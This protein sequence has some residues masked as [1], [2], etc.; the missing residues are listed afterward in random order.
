MK[1]IGIYLIMLVIVGILSATTLT[2]ALAQQSGN[3]SQPA[4]TDQTTAISGSDSNPTGPAEVV[5]PDMYKPSGTPPPASTNATVYF[6][7]QDEN[8]SVTILFLYNTNALT[9]TVGIQS[10]YINGSLTISTTL[11]VPPHGLVRVSSDTV[12]TVSASWQN[13]VLVNFTTFSAYAKMTLPAAIKADG[14]V[15]WDSSG[16]YDPLQLDYT[17]P[18]RFSADPAT[19]FLPVLNK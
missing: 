18:I 2:L 14:Y 8:T 7:P 12:T 17:L 4:K 3:D 1:K 6:T 13:Y 10:F 15:A 11:A 9:E 16:V 5:I 19:V